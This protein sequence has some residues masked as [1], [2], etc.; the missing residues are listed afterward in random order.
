MVQGP[1]H[2]PH[3]EAEGSRFVQPG[4]EKAL[5]GPTSSPTN[6]YEEVIKKRE[7]GFSVMRGGSKRDISWNTRGFNWI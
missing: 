3:G 6:T 5:E 2:F 4:E 1:E 7:T